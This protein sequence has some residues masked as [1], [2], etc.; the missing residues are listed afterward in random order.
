M[1][2]YGGHY[3]AFEDGKVIQSREA[4]FLLDMPQS[5]ELVITYIGYRY[6][7]N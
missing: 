5:A 7:I 2:K 6:A 3:V 1:N 4:Q